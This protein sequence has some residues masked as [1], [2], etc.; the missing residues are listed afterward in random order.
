VKRFLLVLSLLLLGSVSAWAQCIPTTA[1]PGSVGCFPQAV[2]PS[3]T[4]YIYA[5]QPGLAPSE[6]RLLSIGNLSALIQSSLAGQFLPI[7]GGTLTGSLTAPN[8]NGVALLAPPNC[9]CNGTTDDSAA[10]NTFFTANAGRTISCPAGTQVLFDTA[11]VTIQT[12]TRLIGQGSAHSPQIG[13]A[14]GC[15][16]YHDPAHTLIKANGA[17]I[18]NIAIERAG[19]VANPTTAQVVSLRATMASESSVGVIGN[20]VAGGGY[21]MRDLFIEGFHFGLMT[22]NAGDWEMEDIQGDDSTLV[23]AGPTGDY[24][25]IEWTRAE[26]WLCIGST[27]CTASSL[28]WANPG[29]AFYIV[30]AP[31]MQEL[32]CEFYADCYMFLG[33]G[34]WVHDAVGESLFTLGSSAV[35]ASA[36]YNGFGVDGFRW[37]GSGGTY[38]EATQIRA[39][40]FSNEYAVDGPAYSLRLSGLP[41]QDPTAGGVNPGPA[42]GLY[43]WSNGSNTQTNNLLTFGGT[44]TGSVSVT[45]SGEDLPPQN[46]I[47]SSAAGGS[48]AATTYYVEETYATSSTETTAGIENL[49]AVAANKVLT[50]ASPPPVPG[51]TG[52]NV[53]VATTSG[54]ETEQNTSPIAF[55]TSWTEPTTGLVTGASP[56]AT[57][58]TSWTTTDGYT[59][60]SIPGVT[61]GINTTVPEFLGYYLNT[62]PILIGWHIFAID[63]STANQI[64]IA[65]PANL[66][67]V[68]I[69]AIA[70]GGITVTASNAGF[71]VPS[72]P[73]YVQVSGG[74]PVNDVYPLIYSYSVGNAS[75]AWATIGPFPPGGT[76]FPFTNWVMGLT[77]QNTHFADMPWGLLG[78]NGGGSI[79]GTGCSLGGASITGHNN[80]FTVTETTAATGCTV[81]F[82]AA[83]PVR[84]MCT[85]QTNGSAQPTV[86]L[87]FTD[88]TLE[89]INSAPSAS[90]V[91]FVNCTEP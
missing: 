30:G 21:Y 13:S 47:L 88:S 64:E 19:M 55:G 84:P 39:S 82:S 81:V 57:N 52:Y 46:P 35:G 38:S 54:S 68:T 20:Q 28:A 22:I 60:G 45:I 71:S 12:G 86:S 26:P 61:D 77:D 41:F 73:P 11:N 27:N 67:G 63:T 76:S 91:V 65:V 70:S 36:P 6:D 58:N 16:F 34:T 72:N 15:T 78:G 8:V 32:G 53:Y 31:Y 7:T 43:L 44:A 3:A 29:T 33:S 14:A 90:E 66:S 18:E 74:L 75:G 5:W 24:A 62:D 83:W 69:S 49:L 37:V 56:P 23:F 42:G 79:S 80:R 50:V 40:S 4:D 85:F 10:L 48:L 1:P 51:A 87:P 2:S 89:W 59:L 9:V 25:K 17:W